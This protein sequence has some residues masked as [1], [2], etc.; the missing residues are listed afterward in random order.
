[1][2]ITTQI[3]PSFAKSAGPM[4]LRHAGSGQEFLV[5]VTRQAE[6]EHGGFSGVVIYSTTEGRPVGFYCEE[7]HRPSF[8]PWFGEINMK[9]T[10]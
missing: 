1:M 4:V 5:L 7:F 6:S 10:T 8:R 2:S 9:V 3:T